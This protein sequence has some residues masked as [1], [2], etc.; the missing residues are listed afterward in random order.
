L[1]SSKYCRNQSPRIHH[2]SVQ[3][4]IGQRL[5]WQKL[6]EE[7]LPTG[8]NKTFHDLTFD[9]HSPPRVC[10]LAAILAVNTPTEQFI[11]KIFGD[12]TKQ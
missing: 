9:S 7:Y 3:W 5:Y 4:R 11:C 12:L 8:C 6:A 1:R 10:Q 2:L